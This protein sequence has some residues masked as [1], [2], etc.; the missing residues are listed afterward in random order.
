MKKITTLLI[1]LVAITV[2]AQDYCDPITITLDISNP[3]AYRANDGYIEIT[4]VEGGNGDF[5]NYTYEWQWHLGAFDPTYFGI[6]WDS[7]FAS[8]YYLIVYD[9]LGCRHEQ[10][11][12]YTLTHPDPGSNDSLLQPL[13]ISV[14]TVIQNTV[15]GGA[16]ACIKTKVTGGE[17]PYRYRWT[18]PPGGGWI[19]NNGSPDSCGLTEGLYGIS[20][21][22]ATGNKDHVQAYIADPREDGCHPALFRIGVGASSYVYHDGT[23]M[24]ESYGTTGFGKKDGYLKLNIAR[25]LQQTFPDYHDSLFTYTWET[26]GGWINHNHDLINIGAGNYSLTISDSSGCSVMP[27]VHPI[28]EPPNPNGAPIYDTIRVYMVLDDDDN[29]VMISDTAVWLKSTGVPV[30]LVDPVLDKEIIITHHGPYLTCNRNWKKYEMYGLS[31]VLW[32]AGGGGNV[33]WYNELTDK[34]IV[35]VLYFDDCVISQK[36]YIMGQ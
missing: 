4:N 1:A 2:N 6:R 16:N 32:Q 17:S 22:D 20:A 11:V 10:M 14:D 12:P 30:T 27:N 29:V 21:I 5:N 25:D 7:L 19:N 24:P 13:V 31:G 34:I 3:T 15:K 35:Y 33:I 9:S 36:L 28:T 8:D 23:Q 26:D 18:G